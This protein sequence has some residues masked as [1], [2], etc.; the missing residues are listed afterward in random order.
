MWRNVWWDFEPTTP[1][2]AEWCF[3]DW[4]PIPIWKCG[5][6]WC[7]RSSLYS[8]PVRDEMMSLWGRKEDDQKEV[9]WWIK[10]HEEMIFRSKITFFL[11]NYRKKTQETNKNKQAVFMDEEMP[12]DFIQYILSSRINTL[13][14]IFW[15]GF[16]IVFSN[17]SLSNYKCYRE[18]RV[19]G[20]H[21]RLSLSSWMT[22]YPLG[23]SKRSEM[24]YSHSK[25]Q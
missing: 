7:S 16:S 24:K 10:K 14:W 11:F 5:S 20:F 15:W 6:R 23:S 4:L 22:A 12:R 18:S 3:P 9:N 2:G 13:E 21:Y 25:E 1:R 8:Q 19:Q 17:R